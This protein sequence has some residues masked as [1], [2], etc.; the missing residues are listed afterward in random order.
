MDKLLIEPKAK[1]AGHLN[2][3]TELE[4]K[5]LSSK[6]LRE[7]KPS[8]VGT[9]VRVNERGA[10]LGTVAIA[11]FGTTLAICVFADQGIIELFMNELHECDQ[12]LVFNQHDYELIQKYNCKNIKIIQE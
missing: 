6:I 9:M 1:F 2:C 11:D 10:E 4:Q 5:C 3:I 7:M 12:I 8:Y